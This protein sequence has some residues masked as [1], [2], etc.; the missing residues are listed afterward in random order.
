MSKPALLLSIL[1]AVGLTGADSRRSYV[2][3]PHQEGRIEIRSYGER[4]RDLLALLV[5][6]FAKSEFSQVTLI[7][8]DRDKEGAGIF[9]APNGDYVATAGRYNCLIVAYSSTVKGVGKDG[10]AATDRFNKFRLTIHDFLAGLPAPRPVPRD[11]EWGK[12]SCLDAN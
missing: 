10:V 6:F 2:N 11:V 12:K 7:P 3:V 1:F 9:S 5:P 4:S 8:V